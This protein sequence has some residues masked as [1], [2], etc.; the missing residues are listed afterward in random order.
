[1][2]DIQCK[3][4]EQPNIDLQIC[5]QQ[6]WPGF[7]TLLIDIA[8]YWFLVNDSL[9]DFVILEDNDQQWYLPHGKTF[10]PPQFKVRII[11]INLLTEESHLAV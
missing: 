7:N 8:P 1:M 9:F 11:K 6:K 5:L 2:Q 3:E 10:A 4:A